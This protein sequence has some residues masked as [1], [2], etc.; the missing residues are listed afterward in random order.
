MGIPTDT[1]YVIMSDKDLVKTIAKGV[2]KGMR[3]FTLGSLGV[4][5][6]AGVAVWAYVKK[7][8]KRDV[9]EPIDDEVEVTEEVE[10]S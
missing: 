10:E 9:E 4:L 6:A 8:F 3:R 2:N 5:G 1:V 7:K